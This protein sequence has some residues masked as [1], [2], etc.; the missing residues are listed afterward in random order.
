[1]NRI[2]VRINNYLENKQVTG[3]KEKP[4]YLIKVTLHISKET[5][6]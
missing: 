5:L 2:T 1:M 6:Q 4:E 3:K